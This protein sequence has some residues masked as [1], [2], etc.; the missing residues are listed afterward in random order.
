MWFCGGLLS[1]EQHVLSATPKS[2]VLEVCLFFSPAQC[3]HTVCLCA[4]FSHLKAAV[5][6]VVKLQAQGLYAAYDSPLVT[7]QTDPN[8]P[9]VAEGG[10]EDLYSLNN[11][12]AADVYIEANMQ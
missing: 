11:H 5:L 2:L 8:A 6:D 4:V 1:H 3:V 10:E 7:N 12:R 9:D